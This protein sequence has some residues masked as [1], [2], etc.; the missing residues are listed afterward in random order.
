MKVIA[1]IGVWIVLSAL[2]I[3]L[4][5]I[6][7]FLTIVLFPFDKKRKIIH[8]QCFWWAKAIIGCNPYW[9]LQVCGLENIDKNKIYVV[10]A[11]HQSLADIAVMYGTGMQF[12]WVAKNSLFKIPFIGWCLSLTKHIKLSR[13]KMG[14]I[15]KV[16]R[17]AMDWL[18]KDISV[19]FFPEGTRSETSKIGK[20]QNGAFKLAIQ[21][22]KPIL[23][24]VINGTHEA[25]P[26]G[27]WIFKTEIFAKLTVLAPIE[28]ENLR[29]KDFISLKNTVHKKMESLIVNKELLV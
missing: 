21:G 2:T 6:E 3:L 23:P 24:V 22:K 16:Y 28:T 27:S 13:G 10:V 11:N 29:T 5:F 9:H 18:R 26:K 12:K 1:S 14:S 15:K 25:I 17:E 7:L 4:F 8:S 20:F 19:V